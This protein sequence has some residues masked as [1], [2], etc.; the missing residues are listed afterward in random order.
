MNAKEIIDFIF[1][2]DVGWF[3]GLIIILY[4][5]LIKWDGINENN[6]INRNCIIIFLPSTIGI[7]FG[8]VD[9]PK[10]IDIWKSIGDFKIGNDKNDEKN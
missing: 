10:K 9:I 1:W 3:I 4:L 2:F 7:F 6:N 5:F 8:G